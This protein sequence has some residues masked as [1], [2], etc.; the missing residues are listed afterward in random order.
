MCK[1]HLW[2]IGILLNMDNEAANY[3]L[4]DM[5]IKKH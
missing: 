4:E 1:Y 2:T 3:Y 5:V